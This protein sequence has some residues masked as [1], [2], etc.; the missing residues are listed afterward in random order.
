MKRYGAWANNHV[1]HMKPEVKGDWV[2]YADAQAT[3]EA[4]QR[5]RDEA[6]LY[7]A[8]ARA[9]QES[10]AACV[11]RDVRKIK[12]LQAALDAEREKVKALQSTE[13]VI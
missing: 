13:E 2:R 1:A 3:V 8:Q 7:R 10:L 12:D 6:N 11:D 9:N 5:E 4:L